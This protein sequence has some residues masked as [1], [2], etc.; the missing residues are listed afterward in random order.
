MS[1]GRRKGESMMKTLE[2][3]F[4]DY[5]VVPVVVL[6]DADD[7]IPLADALIKGG[8]PCAE[9]TFRTD[10]AEESIRRIC[11]SFPICL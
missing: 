6:N 8:L 2:E 4:Y 11:E 9:V 7:A 3:R 10:A 1:L 5:A